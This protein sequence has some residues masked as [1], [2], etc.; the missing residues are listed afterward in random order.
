MPSLQSVT[1]LESG[2][3]GLIDH[4]GDAVIA[5]KLYS[6]GVLPGKPIQIVRKAPFGGGYYLRIVNQHL[7]LRSNEAAEI[8]ITR[9]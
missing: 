5:L 9:L 8:Y 3:Q 6:M 4:I 7:V 1:T 2:Q